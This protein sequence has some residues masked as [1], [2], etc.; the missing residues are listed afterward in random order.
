VELAASALAADL[1]PPV[2]P[3]LSARVLINA[4]EGL[5]HRL[6]LRPPAGVPPRVIAGEITR[7]ARAYIRIS[8]S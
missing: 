4:I 1:D 7:L 2:D 6:T 8:S 3:R 5:T